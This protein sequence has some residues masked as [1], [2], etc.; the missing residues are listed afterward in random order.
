MDRLLIKNIFSLF[1]IQAVNYILPLLII[2]Y[3]VRVLGVEVFGV[4]ILILTVS[5]Y[6]I[7]LT[8]YGFNLSA[9]RKIAVNLDNFNY[10]SKTF[11]SVLAA[12]IFLA[13]IG[14]VLLN[15]ALLC[16]PKYQDYTGYLNVAYL[17]VWGSVFFPIWLYQAYEKMVWIAVCNFVSRIA[18]IILVFLFVKSSEDL[19]LAILI[20][21][22]IPVIAAV[23]AMCHSQIKGLADFKKIDKFDVLHELKD[24]W[25]IFI[26]TSFVSLYTTSI[27]IILGMTSGVASVGIFSAADKIRLA[28][29]SLINPVSQALYPRLSKLMQSEENAALALIKK[30]FQYFVIPLFILSL[31]VMIF[32]DKI[33]TIFYGQ[34]MHDV[35][36]LLK[37]LVWIPPIVAIANLLGIQ[38]MLPKGMSRQF[39]IT[40][41][42][43]GIVGFPVLFISSAAFSIWG[44][45]VASILIE[46][47]VVTL[48]FYFISKSKKPLKLCHK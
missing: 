7:I 46:V 35:S 33:I 48:F 36:N 40:Y 11:S 20:Q 18:G 8:E 30:T 34:N 41:I 4:Y 22:L 12:K 23:I 28:L 3:L 47:M 6:F 44:V 45:S 38:I 26:S 24:S 15:L 32:S 16:I 25:D 2:P 43:S 31:G 1:S 21:G 27:P 9:T 37:I 39:S 17:S 14:I 29:Q 13:I 5:Q 42:I 19:Y 10:V